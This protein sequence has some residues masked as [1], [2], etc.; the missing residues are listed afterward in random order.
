MDLGQSE[1]VL[2]ALSRADV[3]YLVVGEVAC[4]L[5][6]HTRATFD[7]D[8]L[9]DADPDNVRRMLDVLATIFLQYLSSSESRP[10][11]SFA[12]TIPLSPAPGENPPWKA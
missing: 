10:H 4:N 8:L 11:L 6:E 5:N 7:L 2:V 3:R 9:N 1:S 12:R